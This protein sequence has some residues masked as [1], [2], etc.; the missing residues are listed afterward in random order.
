ML[1]AGVF[2]KRNLK[3]IDIKITLPEEIYANRE[4][5]I[6]LK[7]INHKKFLPGFLIKVSIKEFNLSYLFPY[8]EKEKETVISIKPIRRGYLSLKEI[9]ISS[10]FPFNFF[11]RWRKIP[12]TFSFLVFP[13]PKKCE[14]F[15]VTSNKIKGD[16]Y[17]EIFGFDGD[18]ISIK[19]YEEGTPVKYIHWKA[20][21]KTEKFKV[22]Q[23]SDLTFS[24]LIIYL[25]QIP[26]PD[27]EEKISC[28]TYLIIESFKKG[29][30]V[31]LKI[32][33]EF[34]KPSLLHKHKIN[35]LTKLALYE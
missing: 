32:G 35:L 15:S 3:A 34:F 20:S 19:D 1:L 16:K 24:P 29:I 23:F 12:N 22:K 8:F 25:E 31:G 7:I 26:I 28:A 30:P 10:V 9:Y 5:F 18:L 14:F 11:V 27:K 21:A 4:N 17:S 33:K 6:K 2:G 13:E